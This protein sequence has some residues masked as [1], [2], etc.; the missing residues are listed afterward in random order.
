MPANDISFGSNS[1]RSVNPNIFS[2]LL[3]AKKNDNRINYNVN[4]YSQ[5]A[6]LTER[7]GEPQSASAFGIFQSENAL[8]DTNYNDYVNSGIEMH[9]ANLNIDNNNINQYA[10]YFQSMDV[11]EVNFYYY[12]LGRYGNTTADIYMQQRIRA[13]NNNSH[14]NIIIQSFIT[15]IKRAMTDIALLFSNNI[16]FS[17]GT[18]TLVETNE[19]NYL[20]SMADT[21]G[22]LST[23]LTASSILYNNPMSYLI[24]PIVNLTQSIN[25]RINPE[26]A[27]YTEEYSMQRGEE[28]ANY[29]ENRNI[30]VR[31]AYSFSAGIRRSYT[32]MAQFFTNDV[33]VTDPSTHAMSYLTMN[34]SGLDRILLDISN[35][36]GYMVPSISLSIAATTLGVPQ[37]GASLLGATF[38]GLYSAGGHYGEAVRMGYSIGDARVYST[39]SGIAEAGMQY[40]LGGI[41]YLGGIAVNSIAG[42]IIGSIADTQIGTICKAVL[43]PALRIGG[44]GFEEYLQQLISDPIRHFTLEDTNANPNEILG[45][46]VNSIGNNWNSEDAIYS[47]ALG[48][49]TAGIIDT[50]NNIADS[51]AIINTR[52]NTTSE[53]VNTNTDTSSNA[54]VITNQNHEIINR[55][56]QMVSIANSNLDERFHDSILEYSTNFMDAIN[57]NNLDMAERITGNL[58]DLIHN[59]IRVVY[60]DANIESG[61]IVSEYQNVEGEA[62]NLGIDQNVIR[63]HTQAFINN[64]NA[65]RREIAL[66]VL[67]S[68]NNQ[69]QN[70]RA[71]PIGKTIE[72]EKI[73]PEV[74]TI[75]IDTDTNTD[76]SSSTSVI[77]DQNRQ[78]ID[79]F[80]QM[81]SIANSN[82]DE[83]FHDSILEYSTNFMDAINSNNLDM[84][85]RITGNLEDLIHNNIRV[86]YTDANIESGNI[87]SEYQNVEGEAENLGIDQN[88][89][90][91]HTQAFIN[92]YNAGRREIALDV[93][94]SLN[95]Q[96]QNRRAQPIGKTI[97]IEKIEPEVDTINIDTDTN[98]D[99]S[100][101]TSVITDQN[102][103]IID[104]FNQMVSI[105]NSNLD[106]RFHDSILEYSTNFMDAINSNNLDMAERITGNL[107]D[108]IHNNIRVV[109]TDANIESGN[110]VSEYQNVE[111]EAENLGIDQN[112]IRSHTQAFINNY[113]AGRREI[114]L[115]VLNSLNNQVQNRRAQNITINYSQHSSNDR[116]MLN[117][118]NNYTSSIDPINDRN[119]LINRYNSIL[120]LIKN[121]NTSNINQIISYCN[122]MFVNYMNNNNL[123]SASRVTNIL[124]DAVYSSVYSRWFPTNFKNHIFTNKG[125]SISQTINSI[126]IQDKNNFRINYDD[127]KRLWN[128]LYYTNDS[129][130]DGITLLYNSLIN[131]YNS[132]NIDAYNIANSIRKM[133]L[134]NM[135]LCIKVGN[136]RSA[137]W[138]LNHMLIQLDNSYI[139][140]ICQHE[141]GHSMYDLIF[142]GFLPENWENTINNVRDYFTQNNKADEI[143]NMMYNISLNA[144]DEAKIMF[145]D[146]LKNNGLTRNEYR[147]K[148]IKKYKIKFSSYK[149]ILRQSLLDI[150]Y[151]S[152]EIDDMIENINYNPR[153]LA[154]HEINLQIKKMKDD[155]C[156]TKYQSLIAISDIVDAVFLGEDVDNSNNYIYL[157][158]KH[159]RNY[160]NEVKNINDRLQLALHEIMANYTNIRLNGSLGDIDYLESLFGHEFVLTI[161]GIFQYIIDYGKGGI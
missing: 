160:Y 18:S 156:R 161:E 96:V 63:S 131:S 149:N 24:T 91:S 21:S 126:N 151:V 33:L 112:V 49:I 58:E 90:R 43:T 114:A 136:I 117:N 97:E 86:V 122:N 145:E 50:P 89:I 66:D 80:N 100:S 10:E 98:T 38:M 56:N 150:G 109:Y 59:N 75:N 70:R 16:L 78:I 134:Q 9:N 103:Q 87:V 32:D 15:G 62:E 47:A 45:Y 81:V 125:A 74:D 115:D 116:N 108:L 48:M 26:E 82:L 29:L 44:E 76:T 34:E 4:R 92:N 1:I 101:S 130:T 19:N 83:R 5:P 11:N 67:N 113:N 120:E 8:N 135:G 17:E 94:N 64:Y 102:R 123:S 41:T 153:M 37:A 88:V 60:T 14:N 42:S 20:V 3:N 61:N 93:L 36:M 2:Q 55:F 127:F 106:E 40:L 28:I 30:V 148:L 138:N 13:I 144:E 107:E 147:K 84:A 157:H 39:V 7:F 139:D 95:N 54:S 57:S 51:A 85:E 140:S 46:T 65:G 35:S 53:I 154:E 71:Q 23:T 119:Q 121:K 152:K 104:R 6:A 22:Y 128:S 118:F 133:K 25:N 159:G 129:D 99:T 77:T 73:E 146:Y 12:L 155:I 69:V 158:Y 143:S 31:S 111:G 110:I 124:A 68:L 142:N 72:I 105:A 52:L 141:T 132:G 137:N 79:R 27:N